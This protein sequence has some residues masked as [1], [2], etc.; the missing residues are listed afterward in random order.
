MNGGAVIQ[1]EYAAG[2]TRVDICVTYK[3]IR[4][5]LEQKLKGGLS[6]KK[7]L[8]QLSGYMD[9]CGVSDGWL[10]V[11]DRDFKKDWKKKLFWEKHNSGGMA[12]RVVGC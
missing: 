1:R 2:K 7:S 9:R 10:I 8:E 12:M 3:G 4:Y 11:F 6:R 5:P